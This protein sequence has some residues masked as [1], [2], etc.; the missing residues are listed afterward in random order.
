M[1]TRLRTK[2][3]TKLHYENNILQTK[4]LR[5]IPE[6]LIYNKDND[7][8][9]FSTRSGKVLG[10][11]NAYLT[12]WPPSKSYYPDEKQTYTCL[13]IDGL[14]TFKKFQG[15][16]KRF[17][18]FAKSISRNSEAK[19][20]INILAWCIDDSNVCPQVFYHKMGFTTTNKKHLAE[21]IRLEKTNSKT[22]QLFGD[23]N[24]YTNMYLDLA[25]S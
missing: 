21:I 17:I 23:G 11:M 3:Y 1:L 4:P 19:G 13:Y 25:A 9:M 22:P 18:E 6:A 2:H 16:G 8:I 5:K 12:E 7:Y 15:V 24:T 20:K 14:E 10:R